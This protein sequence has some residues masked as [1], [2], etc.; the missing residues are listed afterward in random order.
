RD[1]RFAV[2]VGHD[3]P[4]VSG[5]GDEQSFP[6]QV[7]QNLARIE[8]RTLGGT[9][10]LG[11]KLERLEIELVLELRGS[12]TD[13]AIKVLERDFT[14]S[15]ASELA[16]GSDQ[17]Q[18]R[19]ARHLKSLPDHH[20][21]IVDNRVL[22]AVLGHLAADVLAIPLGV[23]FPQVDADDHQLVLV[24]RL[25]P[26]QGGQDMVTVDAAIR[27]EIEQDNLSLKL[28]Q[29]DRTGVDPAHTALETR[30]GV[31]AKRGQLNPDRC[32]TVLIR[33]TA[34]LGEGTGEES[35]DY[36]TK[37]YKQTR[38]DQQAAAGRKMAS[39]A[40]KPHGGR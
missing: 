34:K 37:K 1:R 20:V 24:F 28:R 13:D 15:R 11:R 9:V 22:D 2:Q 7:G 8:E 40:R 38:C 36:Q 16:V 14:A 39:H 33:K 35:G 21:G 30:R 17:H 27:P 25:E 31:L 3:D 4:V 29:V 19:P 12:L 18:G 6:D 26:R 23:E 5:V 32:R 10:V